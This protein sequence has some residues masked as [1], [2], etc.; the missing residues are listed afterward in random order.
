MTNKFSSFLTQKGRWLTATLFLLF[1]LGIGNAWGATAATAGTYITAKPNN[2]GKAVDMSSS[3]GK[4]FIYRPKTGGNSSFSTSDPIGVNT[5]DNTNGVAFYISSSMKFY[6]TINQKKE[7]KN[8]SCDVKVYQITETLLNTIAGAASSQLS[9]DPE[10][11]TTTE[12]TTYKKTVSYTANADAATVNSAEVT[13]P[14]GYYYVLATESDGNSMSWYS[15]TLTAVSSGPSISGFNPT[16]G[17]QVGSTQEITING[18][19]GSTVYYLWATEAPANAAA[20]VSADHHGTSGAASATTTVESDK[21]LYAVAVKDATN[22]AVASASYTIDVTAP[23]LSSSTPANNATNIATSGN[24]VL[25]FSENVSINDASKFTLSG[26][27]LNTAGATVSG[28]AVTI[29]YSGLTEGTEYTFSTAAGAVK[30][31]ANNTSA[32]LSDITFTTAKCAVSSCGNA[33]LTYTINGGSTGDHATGGTDLISSATPSNATALGASTTPTYVGITMSTLG[34]KAAA[35][36]S[37]CYPTA[38]N[39]SG[40]IDMHNGESYSSTKYL[41]FTFTVN[42]GYTFTPC[43]IQFVVQPVSATGYFRWEVTDGTTS[44]GH[45]TGEAGVGSSAGATVLTG[46]TSTSEMSAGTYYIRLYPYY[47]GSNTF[48]ISN[49][50]ILRGTT[51]AAGACEPPTDPSVTSTNWIYVPGETINLTASATGTT[52]ST[53]YTWYKGADLATAKAAGAIQAAKT[54]AQ[55]GTTYSCTASD[56]YRYWCVISNGTCEASASYDIKIYKFYLY[57]N[58][59]SDVS[60]A[61]FATIDRENNKISVDV[62]LANAGYTYKFKVTDG[63]GTW[64]GKNES[65]ITSSTNWLNGLTSDGDNVGLTSTGAG[66]YTIDYYYNVN[67]VVVTY[68]TAYTITHSAATNGTYTIKVGDASAVS[69]DATAYSGQTITL[70]ATPEDGYLFS[71]WTVMNGETPVEVT[72]NQFTM[73]AGNVTV[74]ATFVEAPTPCYTY[75]APLDQ[76]TIFH[77]GDVIPGST[78]GQMTVYSEAMDGSVSKDGIKFDE[79]N[80]LQLCKGAADRVQ[81]TLGNLMQVGTVIS[82]SMTSGS[83]NSPNCL[84]LK[85]ESNGNVKDTGNQN[86]LFGWTTA[87]AQGTQATFTYTVR[88]NDG[89]EGKNIFI[90]ERKNTVWI[91]SISVTDCGAQLYDLSSAVSVSGKATVTL[92]ASKLVSGAT[93]TATYSEIDAAYDF[94]EWVVSG[95]TIDDAKANPVTITMGS[96]DATIT[97]KLKAAAVKHTVTYYNGAED[98]VNKLGDELVVEGN[99]PTGAGLAPRKLGYTFAG[100]STSNGGAVVALNTI[101]VDADMPLFAVW[102]AIDCASKTG[103]IYTMSIAVAPAANCTIKTAEGYSATWDLY[104]YEGVSGG[105]AM[106]G[107]TGGSNNCILQTNKTVLLKDN[108][109]YMKL[110]FDCALAKDDKI[111]SSISGNTVWVSTEATR[112]SG[113][114][115]AL[116]VLANSAT[117]EFVIPA[118]SGLIGEQTIYL[119]K[120]GG[121]ATITSV[122]I[123]RPVKHTVTFNMNGHGDAV[124]PEYVVDGAKATE[125]DPAPTAS[126]YRFVEWQLS[127]SAYDFDDAVTTDI[128]LDAVWQKTW[129]VTFDSDGGSDVA[130]ATV[131]DGQAVA[132]PANPTKSGFDFVVWQLNSATYNFASAVEANITLVATWEVAQ[133]DASLSALSYNSNAIDVSS[134]V[135]VTGVKTY[136]VHLPWGSTIDASL[137]S[138][139]KNAESA[140]MTAIVY[141]SENKRASFMVTSGNGLVSINYAIQFVIDPKRGTSIIK[142][143]TNNVVTGLIGG[144]IDQSYSGNAN[145]RK[146]NKGNYFGVTLA[147]DETFQEGDVFIVNITTPADLGKFMIYADKDRNELIADQGIVYT[148]P[149]VASPVVCPTGEM[150]LVLPATANGKKSLYLSRENVDNTEQWNVTFSSLEVVREMSPVIKSFKFGDD[151]ATINEGAKTI[152]IEMPYS[153]DVTALTPTVEAYGNNGATYTPDGETDFTSPVNYVVTDAYGELSTTYEV[154]VTKAPA[155]TNANLA[156]LAV[157]GYSLDFDPA[158]VTYNVVLDYGTTVLPA[159]TYEVAEVGLA[160]AVK[161]EG[162]VSGATTITVT[163]EA[164]AGHEKV[165]TINFSVSTNP[166][167]VIY[168]GSTMTNIASA[169]GAD[170][171]TGFSYS[172]ASNIPLSGDA[173]SSSW[174]G[175]DY[176]YVIKGF[177]PT[178]NTSNIVSFVVPEGYVAKVRLVGTTNST[179]TERQMFIA[180]NPSKNVADAISDYIIT[181][182]TYDAQGF[183]TDY[184]LP[185]TYYLGST[186]SYRLY[187]F[188]VTLYPIDEERNMTQGR[189]GT[190]C[191][192]YEGRLLGAMLLEI[193]YFDPDQKKIFFDEVIDG[194][195]VA[196]A[197]YLFLPNEGV[198]KFAI[199]Y[200]DNV[201]APAG[202][203]NGLY[204][205]Y[206]QE[207]LPTDGNHYIM[208]N[209]QYCKVVEA[210]TYVGANRA[211]IKLDKIGNDYFAPSYGRRRVSLGVQ[212]AEVATGLE[213]LN[214]G[215]QP[216]KIMIN[217]QMYILRGE[218]M[219]D[220]TGRLVK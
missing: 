57:D 127:G 169:T 208:L 189:F 120:G 147:N 179:G 165:Y 103:T 155:S 28:A 128:E 134:A 113:T 59:G 49:D 114:S 209:N 112:P 84:Y 53:T 198:D 172:M 116:A 132:Q 55:G 64:Y 195:M 16:S 215:D 77:V 211:Y 159:I 130:A 76:T 88:A 168:D 150:M 86:V 111:Q 136:T 146:L 11:L 46:L 12:L 95:A 20:V 157:A 74:S 213:D 207:E 192:P 151:A 196:G 39:M 80:G 30:D 58:S 14:S 203:H 167:Y 145:S 125:P 9:S 105:E 65:T 62:A 126:G 162:G 44:Y 174:G 23:T 190:I 163:P 5:K 124:D 217:G 183:I 129:T 133:D 219:Y 108:V 140:D 115:T 35:K 18:S 51:A 2:G 83:T 72:N 110:D 109:S 67:D 19:T 191:Y 166:K 176:T 45:G 37:T 164:G 79:A 148:K 8:K 22:S 131:D 101:S 48:R 40:K 47:N 94:D 194:Q 135:E 106:I 7:S 93:A 3:A 15:I 21:T 123:V 184:L 187:E 186:D 71:A 170:G 216:I 27:T 69:T 104:Q 193:A 63:F 119:W 107:N 210:K 99:H 202:H 153:T 32:A 38:P 85:N 66:S 36:A 161:A 188:S 75:T 56:A 138:V 218:K 171:S 149:D 220:A 121:N 205:S 100:W 92:S 154:T 178:D 206:T 52:A 137:I 31:G 4:V 185:N 25:T 73:P 41:Q 97:L 89:L 10:G 90:L 61:A 117:G 29:P 96:T 43:D 1:S 34:K 70:A 182:S 122:N 175:K 181:S 98:P 214:V 68:P 42:T 142:A 197:P 204:G 91:R 82:V 81:V 139:T 152:T 200:T 78:G 6:A 26:G 201:Y 50:V 24:I 118:E 177:K 54:S 144:T 212:Q 102:N 17:S 87:P 173:I 143:T 180:M 141:D 60:N 199:V 156:S 158:V 160:T 13:L 33:S